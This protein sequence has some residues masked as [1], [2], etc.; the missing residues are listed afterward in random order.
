[1]KFVLIGYLYLPLH[2]SLNLQARY[3]ECTITIV[4]AALVAYIRGKQE[5][6]V[7]SRKSHTHNALLGLFAANKT[8]RN[9]FAL[10][11]RIPNTHV[12][13]MAAEIEK[14]LRKAERSAMQR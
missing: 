10:C 5:L 8:Y 1:M 6:P 7:F 2:I 3:F 13:I 9:I 12:I 4:E 14:K 11:I